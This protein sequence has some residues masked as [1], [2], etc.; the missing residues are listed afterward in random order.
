MLL[1]GEA[2]IG[3]SR[4][5]A[6]LLERLT[7]EPHTRLRYF[8]SPQHTDSALYPIIS[9]MERAAALALGDSAQVKLDKLD[10][11]LVQTSTSKHDAAL[12]AEML[13][14]P[15]DGRYPAI[16]LTPEQRRKRTLEALVSQ[17]GALTQKSPVLMIFEDAHWTDPTS[18][19]VFGLIIDRIRS[20]R[21][22]LLVTFRL[23]F[24]APWVG[25]PYV[26]SLALNRLGE[27]EIGAMIDRV[28]GNNPLPANIRQDIIE[29]TDGIPLFVEEMTKAVLEAG[30]E[31]AAQRSVASV[32][33]PTLGVPASLQASLMARLDRLGSAKEVAQVGAAIGREFSHTVLSAVVSKPEPELASA[34]DRLIAAGLL[35]RQGVPPHAS[36]LF[37]HALVQDA[38]YGALLR[39]RRRALHA[40]IA[41]TLESQ[42]AE[43]AETQ[44]ELLARHCT[45]AGLI[46]KAVGLWDKAGQRSLER[47]ALV[48]AAEQFS[49][50][51]DQIATLPSTPGL[52]REEIKLQVALI[53]PLYNIKGFA[54]AET[55][56]AAERARLLIEQA[57][58]LGEPPEDPLLLF[59]ALYG[60]WAAN[61]IAFNGDVLRYLAAQ[62]VALAEKQGSA[63]PLMIGHRL[64]GMSLLH[65][66]DIAEGRTHFDSAIAFYNPAAHRRLA[67]QFGQDFRVAILC[68]RSFALWMLGYPEAALADTEHALKDA[69]EIGHAAT[70]MYTLAN[71]QWTHFLCRN[72]EIAKTLIDELIALSDEKGSLYWKSMGMTQRGLL[73]AVTGN[74]SDAVRMITSGLTAYRLTGSTFLIPTF[75]TYLAGA[76]AELGQFDDAR[77]SIDEAIAAIETTKETWSAVET[78]CAA[79][80]IELVSP[81]WNAA[82]AEAYFERA[83]TVARQQRAKSW[84]LRAAMSMARLWRDQGKR[85]EA[86]ELLASVY[87]WFTEGFD[88]LDLKEAKKVLD[89]LSA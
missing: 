52:R 84:E 78:H 50:A 10:A 9:Q 42:F 51:L 89:E 6:A 56:A 7:T 26:S 32:P 87:G 61:L 12:F 38:A 11:L 36:Y 2:G 28:V 14:L 47:S 64:M 5:T 24:N 70:L 82:K 33:S 58:A 18:L 34:L 37:K 68:Y 53:T 43:I 62:V 25:R 54:A 83:V 4:L 35:F 57:E 86:R 39:E 19:E 69:R 67:T 49:R 46:E 74:A 63:V 76:Y 60:V 55:K 8:C 85:D 72:N 80:Q 45:E 1:S 31:G 23:E 44:P 17:L 29:R 66:G 22:L 13:S 75:L 77:R 21:V 15:N 41:E 40:R 79:G 81:G 59:S 71:A 88:T 20:I 30:S 27:R 16:E 3:K 73:F 48:E 65:T